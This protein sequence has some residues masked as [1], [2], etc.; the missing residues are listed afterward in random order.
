MTKTMHTRIIK[1][2]AAMKVGNKAMTLR[3]IADIVNLTEK[4]EINRLD[5]WDVMCYLLA[6]ENVK[7]IHKKDRETM[8]KVT[9]KTKIEA[10]IGEI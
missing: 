6:E 8:Y 7:E 9:L 2:L 3:E 10:I 4:K 5:V 1:V